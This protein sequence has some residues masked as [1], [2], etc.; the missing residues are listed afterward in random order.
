MDVFKWSLAYLLLLPITRYFV[1]A[2]VDQ[3]QN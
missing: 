3:A 2:H 1:A